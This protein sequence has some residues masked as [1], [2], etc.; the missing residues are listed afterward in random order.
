[1][2]T[3]LPQ[4]RRKDSNKRASTEPGAVH[5]STGAASRRV[6]S[7]DAD[8]ARFAA[9]STTS[10]SSLWRTAS[11]P[12]SASTQKRMRRPEP[13]RRPARVAAAD[14]LPDRRL[15]GLRTEATPLDCLPARAP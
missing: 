2:L 11:S 14:G 12:C 4:R 15:S 9:G 6:C 13:V 10:R 1:M 7:C 5:R 3:L 8:V